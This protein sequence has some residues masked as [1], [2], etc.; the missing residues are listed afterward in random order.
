MAREC[1]N[2]QRQWCL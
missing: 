1:D 2:L